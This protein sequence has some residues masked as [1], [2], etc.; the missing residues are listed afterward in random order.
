MRNKIHEINKILHDHQT[1][2]LSVNETWLDS[3]VSNS[4]LDAPGYAIYRKDRDLRGGGVCVYVH[5]KPKPKEMVVCSVYRPPNSG[6]SFWDNV[7]QD[8]ESVTG[9]HDHLLVFGDFN[10]N[11]LQPV[12]SQIQ[13][14]RNLCLELDV[15]NVVQ[16]PTR[17]PSQTCLDLA[18][19][20]SHLQAED[21]VVEPMAGLSDHYLVCLSFPAATPPE[22]A[23]STK[24]IR[25]P[26]L[27][28]INSRDSARDL[29]MALE[30]IW[31][32]ESQQPLADYAS[33]WITAVRAVM[34]RHAPWKQVTLSKWPKPSSFV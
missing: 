24:W 33:D 17:F 2:I 23:H 26:G 8:I 18:L 9:G 10:T 13:H 5:T 15:K 20:S 12:G 7:S 29:E 21:V 14:L 32:Q 4:Y 3:T 11:V 6:V 25:K 31:Q 34:D 22:C 30:A 16:L 1:H 19:L 28:R 27:H